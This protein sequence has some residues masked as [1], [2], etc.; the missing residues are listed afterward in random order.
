MAVPTHVRGHCN[1]CRA[2]EGDCYSARSTTSD[3]IVGLKKPLDVGEVKGRDAVVHG[4][5]IKRVKDFSIRDVR[6]YGHSRNLWF[7]L[8]HYFEK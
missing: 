7:G 6:I 1:C 5:E 4:A 3:L 8:S 2:Y